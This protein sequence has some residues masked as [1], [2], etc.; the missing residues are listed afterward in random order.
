[1]YNTVDKISNAFRLMAPRYIM[2]LRNV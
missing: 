1:L 2:L